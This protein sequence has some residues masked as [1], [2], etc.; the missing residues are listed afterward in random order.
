MASKQKKRKRFEVDVLYLYGDDDYGALS[1]EQAYDLEDLRDKCKA[2]EQGCFTPPEKKTEEGEHN[3][4][5][6]NCHASVETYSFSNE[7]DRE[8]AIKMA[9]QILASNVVDYDHSK[10]SNAHVLKAKTKK[11]KL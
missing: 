11:Q 2:D 10:N 5:L 4:D 8:T 3:D 9:R 7:K 1:L 6:S